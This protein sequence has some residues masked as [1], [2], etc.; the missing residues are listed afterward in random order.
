MVVKTA[1][2]VQVTHPAA[3]DVG[4][5][6]RLATCLGVDSSIDARGPPGQRPC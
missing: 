5:R 4:S 1:S 3:C 2:A 6:L